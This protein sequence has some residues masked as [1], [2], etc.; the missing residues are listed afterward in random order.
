MRIP[1][2]VVRLDGG[3][4]G[5]HYGNIPGAS[6]PFASV[7]NLVGVLDKPALVPWAAAKERE[8]V[9]E[10]A[11]SLWSAGDLNPGLLKTPEDFRTALIKALGKTKAHTKALEAA[12][13][14]G[15]DVHA[16]IER[17]LREDLGLPPAKEE[18]SKLSVEAKAVAAIAFDEYGV[19]KAAS[20]FKPRLIETLVYSLQDEYAGTLDVLGD[21]RIQLNGGV[22]S[23]ER[24]VS[25][26]DWKTSRYIYLS[27]CI[28]VSAYRKAVIEMGLHDPK[29]PLNGMILRLPKGIE[30]PH[31]EVR[32]IPEEE[33][34]NIYF[35]AFQSCI[36]LWKVVQQYE[37]RYPFPKKVKAK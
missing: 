13:E 15:T 2:K 4:S 7:T 25:V 3:A 29:I 12:A 20:G 32:Y 22:W 33:L 10:A 26:G 11:S 36:A 30:D 17:G 19:W 31:C 16:S 35:P 24:V 23:D 37:K 8:A 21:H 9:V 5:R 1:D 34:V 28:Q 27:A 18:P 14:I 6:R